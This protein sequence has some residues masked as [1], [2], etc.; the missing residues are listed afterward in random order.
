M[1]LLLNAIWLL[2]ATAA[3]GFWLHRKRSGVRAHAGLHGLLVVGCVV[4]L[5]FPVISMTDDLHYQQ[6]A[7]EDASGSYKKIIKPA[8]VKKCPLHSAD[9]H[10][11]ALLSSATNLLW[12]ALGLVAS[13]PATVPSG[14]PAPRRSGRAP[15]FLS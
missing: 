11:T 7:I 6:F 9:L 2:L 13:Q 3:F 10:V 15:P 4:I 14:L 8:D 12:Q 5:L 1:E